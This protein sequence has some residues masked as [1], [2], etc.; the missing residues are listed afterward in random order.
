VRTA[1]RCPVKMDGKE[2]LKALIETVCLAYRNVLEPPKPP[3]TPFT[4]EDIQEYERQ[5]ALRV[6]DALEKR[7]GDA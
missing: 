1:R 7:M 3:R 4:R 5:K 6:L 2:R